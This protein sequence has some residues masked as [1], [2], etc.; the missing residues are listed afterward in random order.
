MNAGGRQPSLKGGLSWPSTSKYRA[1]ARGC[2]A[3]SQTL[4][5]IYAPERGDGT[6]LAS[7]AGAIY[8]R[9]GAG[10]SKQFRARRGWESNGKSPLGAET[11][12]ST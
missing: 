1:L 10:N 4:A 11:L 9:A 2:P 7:R 5:R 3:L 12:L 6:G 8:S